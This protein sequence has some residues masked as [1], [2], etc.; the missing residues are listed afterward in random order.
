MR[1]I[2]REIKDKSR[3]EEF[4][5]KVQINGASSEGDMF[6]GA[7]A[8]IWDRDIDGE[9]LINDSEIENPKVGQIQ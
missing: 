2:D 1:R 8:I 7:K 5:A 3:I 9:I 6:Y 4:I